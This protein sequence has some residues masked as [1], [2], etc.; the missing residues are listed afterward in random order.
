MVAMPGALVG[1]IG[2]I[3]LNLFEN[4]FESPP[5][6]ATSPGITALLCTCVFAL[7]G[8]NHFILIGFAEFA[9]VRH[10]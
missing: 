5:L 4:T 7:L 9:A 6:K 1:T 2:V 8:Y 10:I 3:A